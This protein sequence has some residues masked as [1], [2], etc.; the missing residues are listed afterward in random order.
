MPADKL[1]QHTFPEQINWKPFTS[2][3]QNE[4]ELIK[5]ALAVN[6]LSVD[7]EHTFEVRLFMPD[8]SLSEPAERIVATV[9]GRQVTINGPKW[10]GYGFVSDDGWYVGIANIAGGN[11]RKAIHI[12][13]PWQWPEF[14]DKPR[15]S[16]PFCES[17]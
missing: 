12:A 3:T 14:D 10:I 16:R 6:F 7:G 15:G 4:A 17:R 9:Q 5:A 2:P 8:G 1:I 11:N 13:Q